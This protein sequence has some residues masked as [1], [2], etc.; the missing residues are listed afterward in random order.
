MSVA[1]ERG[2]TKYIRCFFFCPQSAF[3]GIVVQNPQTFKKIFQGKHCDLVVLSVTIAA[4]MLACPHFTVSC[5][6]FKKAFNLV[7]VFSTQIF[8]SLSF[9]LPLSFFSSSL[10]LWSNKEISLGAKYFPL[11]VFK[12][13]ASLLLFLSVSHS[14]LS[15]FA[16]CLSFSVGC[17][18][19]IV[20]ELR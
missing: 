16:R 3:L 17:D 19:K 18:V 14:Q 13:S 4:W 2:A 1:S 5:L 12:H 10:C 15:L 11:R 20:V 9:S 8:H 7:L 6:G